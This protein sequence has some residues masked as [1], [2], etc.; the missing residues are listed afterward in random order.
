[1]PRSA[2]P[3]ALIG[4]AGIFAKAHD[5]REYWQNIL[6]KVNGITDIP[7]LAMVGR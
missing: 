7:P 3:I 2:T 4:K 1:M 6:D 5:A